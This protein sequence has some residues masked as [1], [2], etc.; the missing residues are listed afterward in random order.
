M[1]A[2]VV[3]S[4]LILGSI[5]FIGYQIKDLRRRN[6]NLKHWERDEP[7]EGTGEWD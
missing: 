2:V 5:G 6:R 3:L 7:L 4:I 1:P